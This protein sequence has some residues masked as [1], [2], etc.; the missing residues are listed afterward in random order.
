MKD[1]LT[2]QELEDL[3]FEVVRSYTH[4][5]YITQRRTKGLIE[6]ET[7]WLF[8]GEFQSQDLTIEEVNAIEFT[9]E[10]LIALDKALN[11]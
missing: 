1:H 5:Q 9:K 8:S 7:T 2:M 4:D 10:E 6:I 11:K 3:G